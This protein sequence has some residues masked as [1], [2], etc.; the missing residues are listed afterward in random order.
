[1]TTYATWLT[2]LLPGGLA[3][4][5]ARRWT[6]ALG[7]VGDELLA[8]AKLAVKAR[9]PSDAPDDALPFIGADRLLPRLRG[10]T[11][12]DWRVRLSAAWDLWPWAGTRRG[13]VTAIDQLGL[14]G[15]TLRTNASFAPG[16]P[17]DRAASKWARW[18]LFVPATGH[19]WT[20]TTWG[21]G[22]W[23][24]GTWGSSASRDDVARVKGQLRQWSGA[25]DLGI[26]RLYFGGTA[27]GWGLG[28]WG[29]GTWGDAG[30]SFID[31]I[32]E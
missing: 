18:W 12:T 29:S 20:R 21:S 10:E 1:M 4:P 27:G 26:V 31:W 28:T 19:P 2:S 8:D 32:V 6:A 7:S 14:V 13:L 22:T 9:M 16:L 23:G 5:W 15:Y 30:T 25:R 24:S 11:L 17:P 3:G